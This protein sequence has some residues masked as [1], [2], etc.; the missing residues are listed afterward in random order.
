MVC[1]HG[2]WLIKARACRRLQDQPWWPN[3]APLLGT[4]RACTAWCMMLPISRS[5]AAARMAQLCSG[6]R[7]AMSSIGTDCPL[8]ACCFPR[9]SQ[10]MSKFFP[11]FVCIPNLSQML[12]MNLNCICGICMMLQHCRSLAVVGMGLPCSGQSWSLASEP[13]PAPLPQLS[14][15]ARTLWSTAS[16]CRLL[17]TGS[18]VSC[19]EQASAMPWS[20][21]KMAVSF[22]GASRPACPALSRHDAVREPAEL[23]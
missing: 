12:S 7:M 13:N 11:K 8:L 6:L 4:P 23:C 3:Q 17:P 16:L 2:S 15:L 14:P 18:L 5:S 1:P 22:E 21:E 9:L 10:I 20:N 19:C